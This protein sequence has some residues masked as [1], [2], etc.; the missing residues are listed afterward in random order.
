MWAFQYKHGDRPLEGYTIQRAAGRGGF[1]EVYYAVSDSGR[2]VALK[3]VQGYEQI[4][5][6]GI[7]QC[8]NLKSP[9]LVSI[10]DVKYNEQGRPFVIMEFVSGPNL[11]QMMDECPA[12]LGTQKAAFF[13]REISKGLQYL[14]DCGIVHRDLKP[15]NVFFE[16]GYVK[17]GDYG[18]SKAIS[19]SQHSGQTVTVGT[20]HYMAPEIGAGK[21]DRSIDIYAMGAVLYEMLTGVPPFVGAS[22]TEVLMKH[23]SAEPDC[24]NIP[25]PFCSAIR[26]AMHKDPNQRFQSVQEMVE[27]VFGAE[28]IQSSV[29][30]FANQDLSMV[31]GR[32]A[33]KVLA[34]GGAGSSGGSFSPSSMHGPIPTP[35]PVPVGA[36]RAE[37]LGLRSRLPEMDST[38]R[39][40]A[41]EQLERDEAELALQ[42]WTDEGNDRL[43]LAA[44]IIM[45][46]TTT[47]AIAGAVALFGN[48][49][50]GGKG[51]DPIV[52]AIITIMSTAAAVTVG[53][54]MSR[55]MGRMVK[56]E[57]PWLQ[58]LSIGA[59]VTVAACFFPLVIMSTESA[60]EDKA[61]MTIAAL[62]AGLLAVDIRTWLSP[63]R[64]L[65]VRPGTAAWAC[66]IALIL[67]FVLKGH[68]TIAVGAIA[69]ISLAM[70]L[71]APWDPSLDTRAP[72]EK[73]ALGGLGIVTDVSPTAR[74]QQ[75]AR[76]FGAKI[77][78]VNGRVEPLGGIKPP[79][80]P[81][82]PYTEAPIT[83]SQYPR[84][85][86]FTPV[87]FL[88]LFVLLTAI[89]IPLIVAADQMPTVRSTFT[90][91]SGRTY[92]SYAMKGEAIAILAIGVNS[93]IAGFFALLHS[94]RKR[95]RG[96]WPYAFRPALRLLC[97]MTVVTCGIVMA[98]NDLSPAG[99]AILTGKIILAGLV[100]VLVT[101]VPR[102]W[103]DPYAK[104]AVAAAKAA[105]QR[106][107]AVAAVAA[108]NDSLEPGVSPRKRIWAL[109]LAGI[110]AFGFAGLHRFY[111]GKIGTGIL[112]LVTGGLAGVGTLIDIILIACG[113]FTDAEGRKVI[114]WEDE[115]L[116][117]K[118]L[119]AAGARA[120]Q[121][122][123]NLATSVSNLGASS[124]TMARRA[125]GGIVSALAALFLFSGSLVGLALAADVPGMIDA[126]RPDPKI[127]RELVQ[128]L[129]EA[130]F[131]DAP[132]EWGSATYNI[133]VPN[134][135]PIPLADLQKKMDELRAAGARDL[136]NRDAFEAKRETSRLN[137]DQF[138]SHV[139]QQMKDF[140]RELARLFVVAAK[141][142]RDGPMGLTRTA[143][144][145]KAI[146]SAAS[147]YR[148]AVNALRETEIALADLE[149]ARRDSAERIASS[150]PSP[151]NVMVQTPAVPPTGPLRFEMKHSR[152]GQRIETRSSHAIAE[153]ER[154]IPDEDVEAMMDA[155]D[156]PSIAA[157]LRLIGF[158]ACGTLYTLGIAMLML[159]R[160][161]YGAA[162]LLRGT[163]GVGCII[164]ALILAH[165]PMKSTDFW[166]ATEGDSLASMAE[167]AM[168]H[169][170]NT[171]AVYTAA[172]V[173]VLALVLMAWPPRARRVEA[174]PV[175]VAGTPNV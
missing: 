71:L 111:V 108:Q 53:S 123:G 7:T 163:V 172:G 66:I 16:N 3:V 73:Y 167:D 51:P 156:L 23:L 40:A 72:E 32:V 175:A 11:R 88:G 144:E 28:H 61:T 78:L 80:I 109:L 63:T 48:W 77:D 84:V 116:T 142:M 165:Q 64:L 22:P 5:L 4:E 112:W 118:N 58:R 69:A 35:P 45:A 39:E 171:P 21:Y 132:A 62:A 127:K 55:W 139:R 135:P 124:K 87:I 129:A 141:D 157:P 2:E 68:A 86:R 37:L 115:A 70:Q 89:G 154:E 173:V 107:K 27:A 92:S 44:R 117:S 125:G 101:F 100:F 74:A 161:S 174:A 103:F 94:F 75:Q 133:R 140:D 110:G 134:T 145:V 14:H 138:T 36:R 38:A 41:E 67:C 6:R 120:Q 26:K 25:E 170:V 50:S 49:R 46:I 83:A 81:A 57:M 104:Q 169:V 47:L 148:E 151:G 155:E 18:L 97:V 105:P 149:K 1:G 95:F 119:A 8:M 85:R 76:A 19:T 114:R 153:V 56:N 160:R 20:V 54:L 106:A 166:A 29:R 24:T 128:A 147:A 9:Y 146:S 59:P 17:I 90:T 131:I 79:P 168:Q 150:V 164:G 136:G 91:S 12:G 34:G 122:V 126:G 162:H 130:K 43:P 31:A 121:M 52:P 15:G 82:Q 113:E 143:L 13:L 158:V 152:G 42:G 93:L 98:N 30:E 159:A 137:V 33:Q 96:W 65:R 60:F 10:F 99:N 102:S